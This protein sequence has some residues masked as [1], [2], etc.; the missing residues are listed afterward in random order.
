MN[1]FAVMFVNVC[2]TVGTSEDVKLSLNLYDKIYSQ[3]WRLNFAVDV[4]ALREVC[5]FN[6]T[7]GGCLM[8]FSICAIF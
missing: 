5:E 2:I 8:D 3:R 6:L 7:G 1:F 4:S